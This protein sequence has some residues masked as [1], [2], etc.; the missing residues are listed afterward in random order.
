MDKK[1]IV[2]AASGTGGHIYPGIMIAQ[3]LK[4]KGYNPIF[5]TSKNE[6]AMKIIQKS[7][8][9]FIPFSLSGMPKKISLSFIFFC[10]KLF[11]AIIKSCFYMRKLEVNFVVGTGGYIEVPAIIAAKLFAKKIFIHEQNI[12]PGKANVF[13]NKLADATFISF[14][15]TAKFFKKKCIFS[16]YPV[17]KDIFNIDK[18]QAIEKLGIK[19]NVLTVLIFGGSLGAVKLNDIAFKAVEILSERENIQVI[20]IT[21]N[22][23]YREIV[24]RAA[25]K[26]FYIVKDFMHDIYNAYAACDI[27]I[28]R[29][30]AGAVFEVLFLNKPAVFIPFPFAADNH[31]LLNAKKVE[32][33]DFRIIIEEKDLTPENLAKAIEELK[34]HINKTQQIV[35]KFAQEKIAE[36]IEAQFSSVKP[37]H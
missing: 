17:R 10:F 1:N 31:Q 26:S 8:F 9:E 25:G 36:Y 24:K 4:A 28:C 6:T 37:L 33:K 30:G 12:I 27:V 2:I 34:V 22:I 20:H 35:E 14:E 21:G 5:W 18:N 15:N 19:K 32:K 29:A 23:G 11:L 3:E 16:G 7:G 13:A